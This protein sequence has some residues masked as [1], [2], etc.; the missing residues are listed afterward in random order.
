MLDDHHCYEHDEMVSAFGELHTPRTFALT[1]PPQVL[2]F[3]VPL[4]FDPWNSH[5][6]YRQTDR[7]TSIVSVN[8]GLVEQL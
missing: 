1:L 6:S 3:P 2:P 4:N 7:T 8:D 5:P